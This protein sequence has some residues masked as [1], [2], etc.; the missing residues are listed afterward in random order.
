MAKHW[1]PEEEKLLLRL[2]AEGFSAREMSLHIKRTPAAIR[3]R[4]S[5]LGVE[6]NLS[7]AWTPEEKELAWQLKEAG[8][9]ARFIAKQLNRTPGAINTFFSRN[10]HIRYS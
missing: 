2:R 1:T 10:Q 7:R 6:D 9:S 8:H 5:K 3:M 4:L